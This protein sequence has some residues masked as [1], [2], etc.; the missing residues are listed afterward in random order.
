MVS[1]VVFRSSLTPTSTARSLSPSVTVHPWRKDEREIAQPLPYRAIG[2]SVGLP[3]RPPSSLRENSNLALRLRLLP[4]LFC[5]PCG[6]SPTH[7]DC[8]LAKE[9]VA[10]TAC[11]SPRS[12]LKGRRVDGVH[13]EKEKAEN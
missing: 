6:A 11:Q 1:L 9:V 5:H 2:L 10:F 4:S 3:S 7:K 13:E 12:P 8:F